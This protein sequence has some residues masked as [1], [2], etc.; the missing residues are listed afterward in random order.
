M[1]QIIEIEVPDGK[2]AVWRSNT[3]IFEDAEQLPKTWEDFCNTYRRK[4]GEAAIDLDSSI[5]I[6]NTLRGRNLNIDSDKNLLPNI[7][8]AIA[9]RALM[10]L[11]QLRD[12]YRQGWIPD[13]KEDS[14]KY[15][16]IR[17][18]DISDKRY[19]I[20]AYRNIPQFLSFPTRE[21]AKEFL[22]NFDELLFQANDLI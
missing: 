3:I 7:E 14:V 2:R 9:H 16:I 22:T 21:L 5:N 4:G 11:H 19:R 1:K 20:V 8:A 17:N 13:W 6:N 15:N 10:Q 18:T 12:C